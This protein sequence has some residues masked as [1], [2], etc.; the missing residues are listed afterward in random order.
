MENSIYFV[1]V[2][3]AGE[4]Y[5]N[6]AFVDPWVDEDHE[7]DVM[8]TEEGVLVREVR[9]EVLDRV[10]EEF[11]YYG[12]LMSEAWHTTKPATN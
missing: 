4:N 10:R 1:G 6:T 3:Y 9:R 5:G 8:G 7:P 2:N 11:P 12:Q